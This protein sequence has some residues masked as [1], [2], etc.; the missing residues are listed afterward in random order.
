MKLLSSAVLL[1]VVLAFV[2]CAPA[3][4]EVVVEEPDTT[5]ADVAAIEGLVD[6]L[7]RVALAGD[8]EAFAALYADDAIM[9]APESPDVVG[10][11]ALRSWMEE[12]FAAFSV[13]AF[14]MVSEET[15][16]SGDW[17]YDRGTIT[18]TLT[19]TGSEE[20]MALAFRYMMV[21]QRQAAGSWKIARF[22][23]NS[24]TPPLEQ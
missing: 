13:D 18:E 14:D 15:V 5:E 2:A 8:A 11:E 4:E 9:M 1:L 16:V 19:P 22:I 24:N 12:G 6:E 23:A 17:A 21:L 3:A 7:V 20:S 10:I